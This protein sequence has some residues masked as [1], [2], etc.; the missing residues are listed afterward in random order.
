[1]NHE[2]LDAIVAAVLTVGALDGTGHDPKQTVDAFKAIL[3][4]L[5]QSGGIPPLSKVGRF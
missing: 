3:A 5:R 2:Q 4:E 1:M